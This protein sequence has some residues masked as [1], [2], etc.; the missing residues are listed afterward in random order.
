MIFVCHRYGTFTCLLCT[1]INLARIAKRASHYKTLGIERTATSEEIKKAYLKK[2]QEF[3]PD[4]NKEKQDMHKK[5]VAVSE[6]Y[7][8]LSDSAKR[9][10]YDRNVVDKWGTY[11]QS[12]PYQST[13]HRDYNHHTNNPFRQHYA[14]DPYRHNY[15]DNMFRNKYGHDIF[16]ANRTGYS[17]NTSSK[18][19]LKQ[20]K[21]AFLFF[22]LAYFIFL[23]MFIHDRRN[24]N[25]EMAPMFHNPHQFRGH[26]YYRSASMFPRRI[27]ADPTNEQNKP[28]DA[29][30]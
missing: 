12:P 22:T 25:G 18:E 16:G 4:L 23:L 19:M 3:H 24:R 21:Y 5:F 26:G 7:Q 9:N 17:G 1:R 2:C 8:T 27:Y 14:N 6:A 20:I 15:D 11:Y 10:E 13:P 30:N 29:E 28:E